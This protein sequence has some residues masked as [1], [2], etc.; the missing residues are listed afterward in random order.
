MLQKKFTKLSLKR[1]TKRNYE[2]TPYLLDALRKKNL[3]HCEFCPH[4]TKAS[5]KAKLGHLKYHHFMAKYS[6][7]L[8]S[9]CGNFPRDIVEHVMADH[10]GTEVV[11]C[12]G[13][14]QLINFGG[15]PRTFQD[16]AE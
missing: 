7:E 14:K 6:C 13:C 9:Y 10:R 12:L 11:R 4:V 8:C 2:Y 5:K 3:G 1:D 15:D 16:H